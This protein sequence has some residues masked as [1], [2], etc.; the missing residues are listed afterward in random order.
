MYVSTHGTEGTTSLGPCP[1]NRQYSTV[2]YGI[3][4]ETRE[5]IETISPTLTQSQVYKSQTQTQTLHCQLSYTY[6]SRQYT[7]VS[8]V[9]HEYSVLTVVLTVL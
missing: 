5:T 4:R 3:R 8:T 2:E 1:Q 9:Q 6:K 7:V